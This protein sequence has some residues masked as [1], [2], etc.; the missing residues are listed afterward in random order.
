MPA[1]LTAKPEAVTNG[2]F[3]MMASA[4]ATFHAS[5]VDV[6]SPAPRLYQT[7]C[8]ALITPIRN[9]GAKMTITEPIKHNRLQP[10]TRQLE[11]KM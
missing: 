4:R 10:K 8:E 3:H 11:S 6:A 5:G 2:L 7:P 1:H 9:I